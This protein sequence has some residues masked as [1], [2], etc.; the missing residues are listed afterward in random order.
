MK[1]LICVF[2]TTVFILTLTGLNT[3]S[4]GIPS[5]FWN[6]LVD[7]G[8]QSNARFDALE[9]EVVALEAQV[10]ALQTVDDLAAYLEVDIS[11]PSKPVVRIVGA[12]LQVVNGLGDTETK[13]GVGNLIVGYDEAADPFFR[14]DFCSDGEWEDEFTCLSA[15]ETWG[16]NQKSGSHYIVGGS[17]NG[18]TQFGGL[19]VGSD[20]I[21]NRNFSSV[22]GGAL[23]AASG[24]WSSVS[25]GYGNEAAGW[26]SS[27]S[28][29]YGNTASSFYSSVSGGFNNTASGSRSS[30]SGGYEN[31]ASGNLSSVSGGYENTASGDRSSVSGGQ[32]NEASAT[33]SSVSGGYDNEASGNYDWVAGSLW[34]DF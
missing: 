2:L 5:W 31:T 11:N 33:S 17:G 22:S 34:E 3:V 24:L 13:N 32:E 1:K 9:A 4:A 29:G 28:G 27:V 30:V 6:A 20:N 8:N 26:W 12:N 15:N 23:N 19:V 7:H 25:G 18:Y 21:S 14:E 16:D 10:A